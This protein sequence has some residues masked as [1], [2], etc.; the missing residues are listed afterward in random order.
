MRKPRFLACVS[1]ALIALGL[2]TALGQEQPQSPAQPEQTE[3]QQPKDPNP[4]VIRLGNNEEIRASEVELMLQSVPAQYRSYYRTTGRREFADHVV[5]MKALAAEAERRKLDQQPHTRLAL[6]VSRASL[7]A[8]AAARDIASGLPITPAEIEQY[9]KD[10]L[11]NFERVRVSH[12]RIRAASS[13]GY[14]PDTSRTTPI[15]SDEEAQKQLEAIR[16]RILAGESFADLA[17]Q[18]SDDLDTAGNGG[19]AGWIGRGEQVPLDYAF[20]LKPGEL[21]SVFRGPYGFE[22][23]RAEEKRTA[24]LEEVRS[25]I[26][27]IVRRMKTEEAVK[28]LRDALHPTIDEE[29]FKPTAP[30]KPTGQQQLQTIP[31]SP[32]H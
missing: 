25:R 10:H 29:Y 23:V 8:E 18:Y 32:P 1:S 14:Q 30:E 12:I 5:S 26:E 11:Q 15:P 9:Y 28:Q 7:L 4:V 2:T 27:Q 22:L 31:V 17:R 6:Q 19:E 13:M 3:Q 24:P 21:G 16:Q 20:A